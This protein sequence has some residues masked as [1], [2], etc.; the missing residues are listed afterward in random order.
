MWNQQFH[1]LW[2]IVTSN[3]DLAHHANHTYIRIKGKPD[4]KKNHTHKVIRERKQRAYTKPEPIAIKMN[5]IY[6][7]MVDRLRIIEMML[8][9]PLKVNVVK[10]LSIDQNM[11]FFFLNIESC[12]GH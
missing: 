3:T 10:S 1:W 12:C 8:A 6:S 5:F 11:C 4:E 9:R 7:T 2:H